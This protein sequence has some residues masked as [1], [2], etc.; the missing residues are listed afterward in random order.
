MTGVKDGERQQKQ[1]GDKHELGLTNL[2]KA[3]YTQQR[4]GIAPVAAR[5]RE[6]VVQD[7]CLLPVED[8]SPDHRDQDQNHPG[9]HCAG[10]GFQ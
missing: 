9:D 8:L 10:L 5:V 3:F 1:T 6:V 2:T 7:E 4:S